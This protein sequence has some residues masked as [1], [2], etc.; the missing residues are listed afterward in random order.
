[1]DCEID[2]PEENEIDIGKDAID[3]INKILNPEPE[4]RIG[5]DEVEKHPFLEYGK[6]E[7]EKLFKPENFTQEELIINYMENELG[8][9]NKNNE[10]QN[11]TKFDIYYFLLIHRFILNII[12]DII[13]LPPHTIY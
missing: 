12:I 13:I 6:K 8:F 4:K 9:D 11:D 5:L 10:I 1:M 7:Y 2:Y 3:L